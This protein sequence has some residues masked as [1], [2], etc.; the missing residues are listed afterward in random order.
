TPISKH[1]CSGSGPWRCLSAVGP[2]PLAHGAWPEQLGHGALTSQ[3]RPEIVT[4]TRLSGVCLVFPSPADMDD[5]GDPRAEETPKAVKPT[6]KE[7][8]KTWGFR[9]TTI[10]KREG[11][12]DAELEALGQQPPQQ[13]LSLRR[14]GRQPKRTERVEEFL[15]TVRRRGRKSAA[16]SPEDCGEPTSCPA[17]DAETASEGSVESACELKSGS[18]PAPRG[19]RAT[20]GPEA[21]KGGDGEDS[22]D[23]DSDGLTLKELQNRLRSKRG[24]EP[25][26]RPPRG[27]V[28]SRLRRRRREE[29]PA[30]TEDGEV[31]RPGESAAPSKQDPEADPG[32]GAQAAQEGGESPADGQASQGAKGEEP[33]GAGRPKPEC[34]ASDPSALYCICRQPHNNRFM[35]CCDR[36]EEWFHGACVGISEARGRLL[37]RDGEDYICPNCTILQAQDEPGLDS[38]GPQGPGPGPG[39]AD[40]SD[41]TSVGTVEQKSAEDQG[42]KGRIEKAANPSGKKKL[43]IFQ[44][45]VETPGTS[46]CI[47]P[48]CSRAAQP[49]S[50]YCSSDCILKHAAATMRSLSSGRD[51]KPRPK[52]KSKAK[53]EKLGL[54]RGSVQRL[55]RVEAETGGGMSPSL[56]LGRAARQAGV[57]VS[58]VH[59]RPAPDKKENAA[60][61]AVVALARSEVLVKE[62]PCESSTPSW[63]SDHNY[64]AVKPERT[65]GLWPP[66]PPCAPTKDDRRAEE[67]S[68]VAAA[69]SKK[70][71]PSGS[72]VGGKQTAPRNLPKKAPLSSVAA[73]KPTFKKSPSGFT[74][75]IPKRPWL[76]GGAGGARPA[77]L[78]PGATVSAPRKLP[79]AA[80]VGAARKPGA[81]SAPLASPVPGRLGGSGPTPSQPNSQIRQN[82]RRSLKEILW[83]RWAPCLASAGRGGRAAGADTRVPRANDSDDLSMTEAEVGRVA[84]HIE[85]EL[86]GLFRG[87]DTRY[88][89]KYRSI[90]FNLKDPKNQVRP[91]RALGTSRL[92]RG[93][94]EAAASHARPRASPPGPAPA[95]GISPGASPGPGVPPTSP[96][97]APRGSSASAWQFCR[98]AG[99]AP[100]SA[101]GGLTHV[102]LPTGPRSGG[103]GSRGSVTWER[104]GPTGPDPV[105]TRCSGLGHQSGPLLLGGGLFRRPGRSPALSPRGT[106]G[107]GQHPRPTRLLV[108]LRR[109]QAQ[110]RVTAGAA[111]QGLF[112]RVLREEISL[113]KLVR[114][115]PEE[116]VSKELSVWKERPARPVSAGAAR[117]GGRA[118]SE[119]G[120]TAGASR[121]Q[122]VEPRARPRGESKKTAAKP[123][124]LPDMEDSP[125]VSD[126]DEQESA[127]AAPEKSAAP[128]LDV[129]SSMLTDTTGQ[130]RAHLFDL[131]CRICTGQLPSSEDEPAPKK[132]KL[133]APARR[134]EAR[135]KREAPLEPGLSP[136]DGVL[137]ESAA[138][139]APAPD[140][141]AA[142][143]VPLEREPF[144]GPPGDPE[145]SAP[146]ATS[147]PASCGAVVLTTVT[148]SGRDP[149]T[150]PGSASMV[151][152]PSAARPDSAQPAEPRPDSVKPPAASVTLPKSIL[153]K[154]SS[155]PEPRYL[156][157][158]PPSPGLGISEPRS[159]P[160]GDT[161]A[162]LSRLSTIWKGFINMQSVAKFVTK[163]YPVSGSFDYLSEDL[164]DT[165]HVG[166]RIAPRTVWDYVGK[167]RSSASKELSLVRFHPATEEE[168]VAYISLYSYF[169]S[170]G[171][172]GVVANNSRHV[173]DLYL[174]PLSARDPVPAKL[175]PFEGPGLESPRPNLILGLVICQK[176]KR[177]GAAGELD[178]PEEKRARPQAP[179]DTDTPKAP[180]APPPDKKAPKYQLGP[181]DL[182]SS[183][184]PQSPPPP[185]PLPDP[186][187]AAPSS[188][189]KLLS[190]LKPGASST[191]APP[192][193]PPAA[194]VATSC[195]TPAPKTAS[196]LEHILQTLFGKKKA[197]DPPAK[198]PADPSPASPPPGRG[199]AE[200]GLPPAPLLDPIVQQFGRLSRD[201]A[202]EEEEEDRP[203]DP[204]EEYGPE[205]AFG[206]ALGEGGRPGAAQAPEPAE[207]EEVAYDP[208][209]ETILEEAK[210]PVD[211][212]PDRMCA[213]ERP[214]GSGATPPSLVEQ[215][216]ML[217]EL[218]KQIEEQ[219][220]Q[221][222]E[223]EEA[224]RLQRAAAGVAMARFSASGA[225]LSPPPRPA[226]PRA[227]LFPPERPAASGPPAGD[228]PSRDPRQARRLAAES[229]E[230]GAGPRAAAR[231]GPGAAAA[232]QAP[233]TQDEEQP[234]P[235]PRAP[236]EGALLPAQQR[237]PAGTLA[238][239]PAPPPAEAPHPQAADVVARPARR[240]LLPTP[241]ALAF[242]PG[243]PLQQD[244][245]SCGPPGRPPF[246]GPG[247]AAQEVA[248]GSSPYEGP[249]LPAFADRSDDPMPDVDGDRGRP[250]EGPALFPPPGPKGAGPPPQ[251]QGPREP[252]P[253]PFGVPGLHG[254]GFPGPRG[255]V[256]PF[257]EE[258]IVP[259]T[260]GPRGPPPARFGAQ[261][262]P[263]P[264]LFS[265]QHGPSPYGDPRGA[266]PSYL[267]GPRGA[268]P[269]QLEER[270]DPHGEKR[271]FQDS[272]YNEM[273]GPPGQ[274]EGPEPA[275]FM[276]SRGP[277]PFQFGGQRRPLL[278]QFKGPRGGPPPAQ[279][280]GQRGPPPGHFVG[281]RGPHPPQFEA[282]RG[283]HPNQ[284]EGPRGQAPNF[285]PGPRGMQ[286]QQFEEQRVNSPPRFANQRAPAPLPFGGPRG[287]APFP[288]STE[289]AP[290]RFHFPGPATQA[291]KPGPRPLLE[292]PSHPPQHRKDR[293]D[294]GGPAP[295]PPAGTPGPG[296]EAE[297]QWAAAECREGKGHEFR[298]QPFDGRPREH[299]EAGPREKP[300]EEPEAPAPDCRAGRAP[301]ERRREREHG[302]PWERERSRAWSRERDWDR[303]REWDRHREKDSGR[304]W[305]RSKER[306]A[307]RDKEREWGRGRE[308]SRNR[309]RDR[310]RRDRSRSRDREADRDRDRGRARERER[311]RDRQDRSKSKEGAREPKAEGPRADAAAQS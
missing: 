263:I 98:S 78:A 93:A 75:A 179:E 157:S 233:A 134:E 97:A 36:C 277:A 5:Q 284:F 95:P 2:L 219:Q 160:E 206:A 53:P 44:P 223:Q 108:H 220:R 232:C 226:P 296:P 107:A 19:A 151:L 143:R 18:Q 7:F 309:E 169:S 262:G 61:K 60:R 148:V 114:M 192:A 118:L 209:D 122:A 225:L 116:L 311:G 91:T 47:G 119:S 168:E 269:P 102:P 64:N 81:T 200:G 3:L 99:L 14:S 68:A 205:G 246:P 228:R 180:A 101:A 104:A 291:G 193:T 32:P 15:T 183:T 294:E 162:F 190:S 42:I 237:G 138:N 167:L 27:G 130:H 156:L 278:S 128:A 255:P 213:A 196:P 136:A 201:R 131:N 270:K 283:P 23:S 17:T 92:P 231:E 174:I 83:K 247:L 66:P 224:L 142:P 216:Q 21:A 13:S 90:M 65:P 170:R 85:K 280:G 109:G 258:N 259:G 59:K 58:S 254:P 164:P 154:P 4:V 39:A 234:G 56:T 115:K 150:A 217:E 176:T 218:S 117:P 203:Y 230:G 303:G 304:E 211:D 208:E 227:E 62:A 189:L 295:T 165:I 250:G 41:V 57:K 308:H 30:E 141:G 264:S 172:F 241:P 52:E 292:L 199:Q 188:V 1:R 185:P 276:G 268:A 173:K 37:E 29:D 163:A 310:R 275:Q 198:E 159:P 16:A 158:V 235:L 11:A 149:R 222:E 287:P 22:S 242:Q 123:E 74:G 94:P 87:T 100:L 306:G 45:A 300:A 48:G 271:E 175:L 146:E 197:F 249:R 229:A 285:M 267:G 302:K 127:R 51:Q 251:L 257:P 132:Q 46:R 103:R 243:P 67:V 147:C 135:P 129:F 69:A 31:G 171:R 80:V 212:L 289:P 184:P 239:S 261:K 137:P 178:R 245:L 40:G 77:G 106:W 73:A 248:L 153:A 24:Q 140:R 124:P 79:A 38:S 221:V 35:I 214:A 273:A 299:C 125:P 238:G 12:G 25:A 281:P 288:D 34:E 187:A 215:Q 210:V 202:L 139:G 126:S 111:L 26:E 265:G 272:P 298:G 181:G 133:S 89:S 8:R 266:T 195:A 88:K 297:A 120:L 121:L 70:P 166:G 274:F 113:A 110:W 6:S 194:P 244:G 282:A 293:W 177:P 191:T 82:I 49:D 50:V 71:A 305:D 260:D 20:P 253:R 204:E 290:P 279:F 256:P 252:A 72:S 236:A 9:R 186:P 155:S 86:F 84:L 55:L 28:Q 286:P 96:G 10:A 307:G 43:K 63:A 33:E 240:V 152:A 182:A 54:P 161:T 112:H 144:P 105:P 145:S 207:R 76:S 301:E